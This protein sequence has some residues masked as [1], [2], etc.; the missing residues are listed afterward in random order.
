MAPVK[1]STGILW[2]SC[3]A[4]LLI[5]FRHFGAPI[6]ACRQKGPKRVMGDWLK[7]VRH[8]LVKHTARKISDNCSGEFLSTFT[9]NKKAHPINQMSFWIF[10][11]NDILKLWIWLI[12]PV[13]QR[14]GIGTFSFVILSDSSMD[15]LQKIG[16][17][18]FIGPLPSAF[19]DK[20]SIKELVQR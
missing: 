7:I 4:L 2:I 1:G 5:L 18:G 12:C 10:Y 8:I 3:V 9:S 14:D 11:D 6:P 15:R 19:L 16:C 17:Q 13:L 20:W